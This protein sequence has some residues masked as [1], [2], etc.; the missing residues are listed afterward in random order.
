VVKHLH[1]QRSMPQMLSNI[2]LIK[3]GRLG[4]GWHGWDKSFRG[5]V[6]STP[7]Q[8]STHLRVVDAVCS[9]QHKLVMLILGSLLACN[10]DG[11]CDYC[12]WT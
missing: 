5:C 10:N 3:F 4:H 9:E 2:H 7:T 11:F 8:Q 12:C 6:V 1:K